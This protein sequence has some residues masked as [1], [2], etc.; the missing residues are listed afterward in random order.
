MEVSPE[1]VLEKRIRDMG[2]DLG[3]P[4]TALPGLRSVVMHPGVP[5]V[6]EQKQLSFGS[7]CIYWP[8]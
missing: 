2:T 6:L 3:T 7:V 5:V 1:Q 4:P 8:L